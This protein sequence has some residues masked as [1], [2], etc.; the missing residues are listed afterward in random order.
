MFAPVKGGKAN[1]IET[2]PAIN[3]KSDLTKSSFSKPAERVQNPFS[4]L[5]RL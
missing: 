2:G 1:A 4:P 5:F 3:Y